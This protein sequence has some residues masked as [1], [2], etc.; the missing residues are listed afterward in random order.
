MKIMLFLIYIFLIFSSQFFMIKR[1]YSNSIMQN[2]KPLKAPRDWDKP[3]CIMEYKF[4][5]FLKISIKEEN[6]K[7]KN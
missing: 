1:F 4:Y 2:F 3:K 7:H 5:N 6:V